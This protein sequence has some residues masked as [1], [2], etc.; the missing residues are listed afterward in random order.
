MFFKRFLIGTVL[1]SVA[2][3]LLTIS[4]MG[5]VSVPWGSGGPA[6]ASTVLTGGRFGPVG[7]PGGA[8]LE[9]APDVVNFQGLLTDGSGVPVPD[10][11]PSSTPPNSVRTSAIVK[12]ASRATLIAVNRG[13]TSSP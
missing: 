7:G 1:A 11:S 2:G 6:E 9:T 4:L 5:A 10:G 12:P 3:L 8:P 13:N